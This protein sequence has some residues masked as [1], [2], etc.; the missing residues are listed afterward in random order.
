MQGLV[1]KVPFLSAGAQCF[2]SVVVQPLGSRSSRLR[3]IDLGFGGNRDWE[4]LVEGGM[5]S[6]SLR[7][8]LCFRDC[9]MWVYRWIYIVEVPVHVLV[10]D[11][12]CATL[13][14]ILHSKKC[15]NR[16]QLGLFEFRAWGLQGS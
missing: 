14:T 12:S 16:P 4:L 3:H 7:C 8:P 15:H 10:L 2:R 11:Q 5:T 9:P 13:P 1:L 6:R